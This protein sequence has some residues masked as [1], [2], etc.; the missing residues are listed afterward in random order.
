MF[1]YTESS[2]LAYVSSVQSPQ[3][4]DC[5]TWQQHVISMMRREDDPLACLEGVHTSL[6]RTNEEGRRTALTSPLSY[7]YPVIS[8]NPIH[9]SL[10]LDELEKWDGEQETFKLWWLRTQ[11]W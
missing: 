10:K 9:P 6:A 11:L 1:P 4:S 3:P 7:T 8:Q 2:S 5:D